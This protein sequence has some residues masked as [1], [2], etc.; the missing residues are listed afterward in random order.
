MESL[1]LG[2]RKSP[3]TDWIVVKERSSAEKLPQGVRPEKNDVDDLVI[4]LWILCREF[5]F[6]EDDNEQ[7]T[8]Y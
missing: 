3:T 2:L 6:G 5:P 1:E 8:T 4:S 7:G